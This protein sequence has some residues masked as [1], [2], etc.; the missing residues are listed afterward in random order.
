MK[1]EKAK[2]EDS[3]EMSELM[4]SLVKKQILPTCNEGAWEKLSVAM[5]TS[6]IR[7]FLENKYEYDLIRNHQGK[8]VALIGI[9]DL[10]HLYHLFVVEEYQGKGFSRKLWDM[11]KERSIK[12]H[13]IRNFT[14][15]SALNSQAVY[16]KFGFVPVSGVRNRGGYT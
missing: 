10:S 14:V 1:V 8:I 2:V 9:K 6:S 5:S 4:L 13:G 7:G 15:N 16:A 12:D 3:Q 11:A